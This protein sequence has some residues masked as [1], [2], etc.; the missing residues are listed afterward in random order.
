MLIPNGFKA[1]SCSMA[2]V[3]IDWIIVIKRRLSKFLSCARVG[4]EFG[5]HMKIQLKK[6]RYCGTTFT[7][8]LKSEYSKADGLFFEGVNELL[9]RSFDGNKKDLVFY[10]YDVE[11]G[12]GRV[13]LKLTDGRKRIAK[14][15]GLWNP[16]REDQKF[17]VVMLD[18]DVEMGE[19]SSPP[20][21]YAC[22]LCKKETWGVNRVRMEVYD[23]KS[24][25]IAEANVHDDCKL[26]YLE[27]ISKIK[28][29]SKKAG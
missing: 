15:N 20:T 18:G 14:V 11:I 12:S 5:T 4:G 23:S 28:L 13:I 8:D 27:K 26:E 25:S 9:D 16:R 24:K 10:T 6:R 7:L 19:S 21:R 22:H 17:P 1:E 29:N 2:I 3:V